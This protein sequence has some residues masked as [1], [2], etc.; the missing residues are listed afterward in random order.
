MFAHNRC[1]LGK[2]ITA[3]LSLGDSNSSCSKFCGD[4]FLEQPSWALFRAA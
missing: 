3:Y 2:K 4:D 1:I